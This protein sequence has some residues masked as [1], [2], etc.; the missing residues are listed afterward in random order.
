VNR[1]TIALYDANA[2]RWAS[3]KPPV[4]QGEARAF[5]ASV[6][7]GAVRIDVG[8]GTGRYANDLGQPLV[9]LEASA[10]ML[11]FAR[12]AAPSILPLMADV[13]AL[14]FRPTAIAGAW[15]AMTYHHIERELLP[16]ALADLHRILEVGAPLDI[17]MAEGDYVGTDMPSDTIPGR[18]FACWTGEHLAD[19]VT[20]AGFT[21][22]TIDIV[23]G[24][25]THVVAR[26]D[27]TLADTV[28]PNMRV[29][30]CG[31]NPSIY[32]ADRGVGYA[33][34]GNRFWKAALAAGLISRP[35]KPACAFFDHG[36]GM[37]D[38]VKRATAVASELARDEYRAGAERVRRLVEWL[39]PGAVC[40]VGFD[41]YRKAVDRK[42][43]AGWQAELFGGRP[44]YVM[45]ST[46]GLNART[47][48][49]ALA[50]HLTATLTP[51]R[52]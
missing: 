43:T 23:D 48:L 28:G 15:A 12:E 21:V 6:R 38:L 13:T 24:D 34:P 18:Y 45:P 22:E 5:A 41:G 11:A 19:V 14:P 9:A 8:C 1:D 3:K 32:S 52:T 7:D 49:D 46:S 27:R 47:S 40:F 50:A 44:T 42:A 16:M 17:T 10:G 29:L 30:V 51:P 2:E 26:R 25:Q 37:T 35:H 31:L 20:G 36:V 33:R 39:Q 4:R